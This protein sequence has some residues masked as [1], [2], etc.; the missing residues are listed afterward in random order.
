MRQRIRQLHLDKALNKHGKKQNITKYTKEEFL[1]ILKN[2]AI[3]GLS[4]NDYPTYHKYETTN[5]IKYLIVNGMECEIYSSCDN[6][7][8]Y[9]KTEEI[10]LTDDG[11]LRPSVTFFKEYL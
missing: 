1:T 6:A 8:M 11:V 9:Q 3:T 7:L 10:S 5:E 4:G 2:A